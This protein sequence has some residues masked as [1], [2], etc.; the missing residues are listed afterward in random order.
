MVVLCENMVLR[1]VKN[2]LTNFQIL[3]ARLERIDAA[4]EPPMS[5]IE[6]NVI[7]LAVAR[8]LAH[9]HAHG[10]AVCARACLRVCVCECVCYNPP[11]I[12]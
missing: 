1:S 10:N 5:L 7:A 3:Q 6:A 11:I 8:A 9:I 4:E 12:T 2:G